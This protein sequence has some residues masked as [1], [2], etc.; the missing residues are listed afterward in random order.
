MEGETT[1]INT[2]QSIPL[3]PPSQ[4]ASFDL[5]TSG[6]DPKINHIT[7]IGWL[8]P[9]KMTQ[10][11]D[12]HE[13]LNT[14]PLEAEKIMI[15]HFLNFISGEGLTDA[16]ITFNGAFDY[17]FLKA[18]AEYHNLTIPQEFFQ[19]PHI[20]L[21]LFCKKL[22]GYKISKDQSCFKFANMYVP[23]K[24]SGAFIA[25]AYHHRQVSLETHVDM[26]AHNVID[27]AVTLKLYKFLLDYPDF[28]EFYQGE[29]K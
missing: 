15:I 12:S 10:F 26:L 9:S 24:N 22:N 3:P 11:T 17:D 28:K 18:R 7:C 23:R 2:S 13:S 5:E 21:A 14:Y 25:R 27:L 4:C 1:E 6:L 16:A 20:D 29:K 19:I 8:T